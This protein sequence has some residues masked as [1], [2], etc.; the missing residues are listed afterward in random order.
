M[1][2]KENKAG[3]WFYS[4]KSIE[5]FYLAVDFKSQAENLKTKTKINSYPSRVTVSVDDVYYRLEFSGD[6]E[7]KSY[8]SRGLRL[9]VIY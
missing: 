7:P 8:I 4:S 5:N 9:L 6:E 3:P 1:Q 2:E